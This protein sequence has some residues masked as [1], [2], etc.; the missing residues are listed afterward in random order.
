MTMKSKRNSNRL[1]YPLDPDEIQATSNCF[2]RRSFLG[3]VGMGGAMALG[4]SSCSSDTKPGDGK[5]IQG[6]DETSD[7]AD[8]Y[9]GWEPFSDRKVRVG[10]VGY[11]LCTF[12]GAFGFQDHPNVEVV[13]VSDLIPERCQKLAERVKCK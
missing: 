6:F 3:T 7:D 11:G 1:F 2:S 9:K 12:A 13:A 4:F 5:V 10:L 8:L